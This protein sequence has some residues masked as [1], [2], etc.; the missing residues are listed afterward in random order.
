MK[1]KEF[2]HLIGMNSEVARIELE[3]EGLTMRA[4]YVNGVPRLL[5]QDIRNDR[6]NVS[7]KDGTIVDIDGIY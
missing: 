7:I 6:V 5:T 4:V 3:S 2:E 1:N